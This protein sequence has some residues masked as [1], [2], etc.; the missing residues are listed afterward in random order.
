MDFLI[1]RRVWRAVNRRPENSSA[2]A[3]AGPR[4]RAS[5]PLGYAAMFFAVLSAILGSWIWSKMLAPS[6]TIVFSILLSALL[7]VFLAL[8][9]RRSGCGKQAL[10]IGS[11]N[12]AI[13]LILAVAGLGFH[14]RTAI[15]PP[16]P[17]SLDFGPMIERVLPSG[18]PCRE[19]L[20]QFRSGEVFVVGNGPGT[21]KEE[22]AYDEKKIED[23]GGVDMSA[24]SSEEG[25][26]IAGRGCFFTRDVEGLKWNSITAERVMQA[27][28][29]VRFVEGVVSP[30]KKELPITYL[31]KT[32]RGEQGI[33]EVLGVMDDKRNGWIEKGMKFRYK[34][35][36]GTGTAPPAATTKSSL[37][38][39][40]ET[41]GF[42]AAIEVTPGEPFQLRIL[43]RNVSDRGISIDGAGYR[44]DDECFL[45]DAQGQ[46]VPVT[47]VTHDIKIG[48]KGGYFGPGQVAV[49]ETAGLSF[50]DIDKVPASAGYI[51]KA[52]PGRYTLRFRLR[53]PGDDV[54]FAPGEHVWKG[55]LETGPVTIQVK[56]PST[57]SVAPVADSI[58]SSILGPVVERVLNDLQTTRE[59]C[60]LSFDSG[61]LLPVP[62]NITLD[63]LTNPQAQPVSVA[64]AQDSHVDAVAFVT[65]DGGRIVKCGLLCPGLVVLRANNKEWIW[66]SATP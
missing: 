23:A 65:I 48:M 66:D 60:A 16:A 53:L 33:M 54:P 24:V 18:V 6:P 22:A 61:K 62:A 29:R 56:E 19:Q 59:N 12:A 52:K 1:V 2:A 5:S 25:I 7:G 36:Q 9:V 51:A 38:F 44:Q 11:I 8:P 40:P 43:V 31:F 37:V 46:N 45:T 42:Q 50:Q 34:L 13:W 20:F 55:E 57:Q 35:V 17:V 27:M 64:W 41:R 28:K 4:E 3:A 26:S 10:L 30:R 49:F 58:W 63:T 21:S 15:V 32:A 14:A 47:K 39:G